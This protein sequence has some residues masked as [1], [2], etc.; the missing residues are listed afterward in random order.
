MNGPASSGSSRLKVLKVLK[1]ETVGTSQSGVGWSGTNSDHHPRRA[2]PTPRVSEEAGRQYLTR[3]M[4]E[5][6]A[7]NQTIEALGRQVETSN[8][9]TRNAQALLRANQEQQLQQSRMPPPIGTGVIISNTPFK[10]SFS[11]PSTGLST[12]MLHGPGYYH[13]GCVPCMVVRRC[14]HRDRTHQGMI[15]RPMG[16]PPEGQVVRLLMALD[17]RADLARIFLLSRVA[18]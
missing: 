10:P 12:R 5:Q 7:Q 4:D 8:I 9:T 3:M 1:L 6:L 13:V 2:D 18:E 15:N 14:I 16:H 11:T 17:G